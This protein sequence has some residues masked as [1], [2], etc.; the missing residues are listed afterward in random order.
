ME[1]FRKTLR[2]FLIFVQLAVEEP[3]HRVTG[4]RV[5]CWHFLWIANECWILLGVSGL[6]CMWIIAFC[7]LWWVH[8]V[9]T[10]K[11]F[12]TIHMN[13]SSHLLSFYYSDS[14]LPC[15]GMFPC[16]LLWAHYT[17]GKLGQFQTP[18]GLSHVPWRWQLLLSIVSHTNIIWSRISFL[19]RIC[20]TVMQYM[21]KVFPSFF[22]A[23]IVDFSPFAFRT[24]FQV[25]KCGSRWPS[26]PAPSLLG[27]NS[28]TMGA[29]FG[30]YVQTHPKLK[31]QRHILISTWL[32]S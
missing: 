22:L 14:A 31:A 4:S 11:F 29:G 3:L 13:Q 6:R 21:G 1:L 15:T 32:C 23:R 16:R 20:N 27:S 12:K 30:A 19:W 10:K 8:A 5:L 7:H 28:E 25:E 24:A 18:G 9:N 17:G 26:K 2:H